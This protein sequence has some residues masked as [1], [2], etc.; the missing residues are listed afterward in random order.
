MKTVPLDARPHAEDQ[1]Y[2][3][4]WNN[5]QAPGWAAADD[6]FT[7]GPIY[8]QQMIV[9]FIR[10]DLK[11]GKM[12]LEQL[13]QAM[14]E[15]A[16]QDIRALAILPIVERALGTRLLRRR[17]EGRLPRRDPEVAVR[18][19]QRHAA[20]AVRPWRLLERPDRLL[21]RPEPVRHCECGLVAADAVP[22]PPDVPADGRDPEV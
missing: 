4:S 5:K 11:K 7:F 13:V 6:K 8:R 22:E 10:Q 15:P 9:N 18:R 2:L 3:V 12:R 19:S 14:E 21:Q 17:Q 20:A 16:T 1:K